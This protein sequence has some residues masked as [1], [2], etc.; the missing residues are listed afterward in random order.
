MPALLS[1]H[2]EAA[3]TALLLAIASALLGAYS[4]YLVI[5]FRDASRHPRDSKKNSSSPSTH[6]IQLTD[7]TSSK[8]STIP[9]A[10]LQPVR[11]GV[12]ELIGNTPMVEL[13][14][15]SAATGCRILAKLELANPGGSAK[16]RVALAIIEAAE[17]AGQISPNCGDAVFEGTSGSTGIS[18]AM[19]ASAKG[20]TAHIA[21]PDDTST[22]K[23]QLL[24]TLGAVVYKVR[25]ASIVDSDQ[26]VNFARRKTNEINA[27]ADAAAAANPEAPRL[28]RAVFADQ[29]ENEA[30]WHTHFKHTGPEIFAQTDGGKLDAFIT[31]A[32]TGGTIAGVARFLKS[33]IKRSPGSTPFRVILADPQGSGFYNRIKYGVMYAPT[34]QEG[35]RRRHQ[36][37]TIV[38]GI[39]LNRITVNFQAGEKYIDDAVCVSD[40]EALQMAKWLVSHDGI[41]I[42]S[43]SAINCVAT[44]RTAKALGPGH[45]I[46]T[47]LCDSGSRHLSK[48]WKEAQTVEPLESLDN[49]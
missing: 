7:L 16:D 22:E 14:S 40:K 4:A 32:G 37:D 38:E 2:S 34:E 25:P 24:E 8:L 10:P 18:L 30:N 48:F 12:E 33:T 36:V 39:G 41:F 45:T 9:L 28:P 15:L 1:L 5:D 23:V 49:L 31:G 29:F 20:Y 42:G 6:P 21:L 17:A 44:Y 13:R 47:I 46:V 27:A 19:L 11:A 3:P 26:Y 43:S 35:T